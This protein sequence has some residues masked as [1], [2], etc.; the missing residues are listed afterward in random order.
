MSVEVEHASDSTV[1]RYASL[2]EKV[3][4][5]V[6]GMSE[7]VRFV[8]EYMESRTT[9]Q[10][11]G[12]MQVFGVMMRDFPPCIEKL[13]DI[14][15]QMKEV[16]MKGGLQKAPQMWR[17][18]S[19]RATAVREACAEINTFHQNEYR[20]MLK[21]EESHIRNEIHNL[22]KIEENLYPKPL[23]EKY[24]GVG[25]F[26]ELDMTGGALIKWYNQE[27]EEFVVVGEHAWLT[28]CVACFDRSRELVLLPCNHYCLCADC[29]DK[30]G[31]CPICRRAIESSVS[32]E[33]AKR[34]NIPYIQSTQFPGSEGYTRRLLME[35]QALGSEYG[36]V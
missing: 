33:M 25:G 28:T 2:D 8:K 13:S 36:C 35:L 16:R 32:I 22:K 34:E 31:K 7:C 1:Q 21:P 27:R 20:S 18:K 12:D 4:L 24:Y 23:F 14:R 11:F 9:D 17:L 10:Q 30:L 15:D 19:M 26:T 3:D 29:R 5:L 6:E